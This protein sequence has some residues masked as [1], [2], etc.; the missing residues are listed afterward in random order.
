VRLRRESARTWTLAQPLLSFRCTEIAEN[1]AM[2]RLALAVLGFLSLP[3]CVLA[4]EDD[5]DYYYDG[6]LIVD[7]T[8]DQTK[9]GRECARWDADVIL[10]TVETLS[11]NFVGDYTQACEAFGVSIDLPPGRYQ[12]SATLLGFDDEQLTTVVD[13][14]AFRIYEAESWVTAIDFPVDSFLR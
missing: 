12:A 10:V 8:V 2:N 13:L 5:G 4:V 11:G 7:W 9:S 3:G 1:V 6:T 14:G